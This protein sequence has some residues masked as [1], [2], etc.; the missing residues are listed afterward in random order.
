M[1]YLLAIIIY[2]HL[3]ISCLGEGGERM[4]V[5]RNMGKCETV[6]A[7]PCELCKNMIAPNE[8]LEY[9]DAAYDPKLHVFTAIPK[10]KYYLCHNCAQ[11]L[12]AIVAG[13]PV[14]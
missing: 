4:I 11:L 13:I 9:T 6:I 3:N 12:I 5:P 14:E 2:N 10:S 7:L 8:A 1:L